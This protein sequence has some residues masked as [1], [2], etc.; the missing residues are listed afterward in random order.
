MPSP[1][2]QNDPENHKL[3]HRDLRAGG[4]HEVDVLDEEDEESDGRVH[5]TDAAAEDDDEAALSGNDLAQLGEDDL[6]DMDGP[7]A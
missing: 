2:T 6:K 7:D 4:V 5:R 3:D 1:Q